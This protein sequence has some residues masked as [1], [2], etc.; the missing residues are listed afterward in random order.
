MTLATL[1]G[2]RHQH[3]ARER[4]ECKA[5]GR[6]AK[7]EEWMCVWVDTTKALIKG[8]GKEKEAL[9]KRRG[10]EKAREWERNRGGACICNQQRNVR[11]KG[12]KFQHCLIR[13]WSEWKPV[14]NEYTCYSESILFSL[15]HLCYA[16][17]LLLPFIG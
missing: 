5:K 17:F 14:V 12:K 16:C 2:K 4:K 8:R 1:G 10:K 6:K 3:K 15:W 13:E 11:D 7:E 9:I